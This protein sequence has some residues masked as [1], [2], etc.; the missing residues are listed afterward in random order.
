VSS[1]ALDVSARAARAHE[2][3]EAPPPTHP[4]KWGFRAQAA[5]RE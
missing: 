2:R 1:G 4:R 5:R 3:G